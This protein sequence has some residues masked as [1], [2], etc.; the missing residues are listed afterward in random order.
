MTTVGSA[1]V[2]AEGATGNTPTFDL[3]I[4]TDGRTRLLERIERALLGVLPGRVAIMLRE[5]QLK[6]AE[7]F[8]LGRAL[9]QATDAAGALLLVSDR[10]DVALAIE[11]DGV[12]LPES[13]FAPEVARGLLGKHA[14]LGASRHDRVGLE[15]AAARGADFATLSPLHAV[16]GKGKP[17]GLRG[18]AAEVERAPLPVYALGGVTLEDVSALRAAGAHGI[19]VMREVLSAADPNARTRDLLEA[20]ARR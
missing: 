6:T 11:A 1:R 8:A 19:A 15:A 13:G 5:P 3:L 12:Q 7:L 16:E 20:L 9:R 17:L 2:H 4:I 18:F 14:I 10:L